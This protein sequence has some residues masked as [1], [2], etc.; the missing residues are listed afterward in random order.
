VA[1]PDRGSQGGAAR[2][3]R[4][5]RPVDAAGRARPLGWVFASG[6]ELGRIALP[7]VEEPSPLGKVTARRWP[8]GELLLDSIDF[9]DDAE[10]GA[11]LALDTGAP[12]GGLKGV[13][14]SLRAAFGFALTAAVGRELQIPVSPREVMAR[15]LD[16]AERGREAAISLL[17]ELADRRRL[18]ARLAPL[19]GARVRT[20]AGDPVQRADAALEAAGARMTR[21]RRLEEGLEVHFTFDGQGFICVADPDTLQILDAGICLAGADRELTLDSLPSVI[22]EAIETDALNIT[23]YS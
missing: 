16:V 7:P 1:L 10:V 22:R 11:R 5:D 3:R 2:S 20:R 15:V 13:T 17:R 18:G 19:R 14:P 8:S 6:R 21:T 12:L 23:R 9:E 4:A